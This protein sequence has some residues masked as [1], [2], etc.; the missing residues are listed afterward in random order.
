[1][2]PS[3]PCS[4]SRSATRCCRGGRVATNP[5]KK[6]TRFLLLDPLVR[7]GNLA[8]LLF[9]NLFVEISHALFLSANV[10]GAI[11][12]NGEE[13]FGGRGIGLPACPSLQFDKG[14]LHHI[15]RPLAIAE[16]ARLY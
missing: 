12:A 16:N 3:G 13:P 14:L 10:K 6:A 2:L 8:L 7:C 9:E 1:M 4:A 11:A 15:P 5:E